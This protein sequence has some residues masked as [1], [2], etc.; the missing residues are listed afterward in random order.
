MMDNSATGLSDQYIYA[1]IFI[2]A[3]TIYLIKMIPIVI[4]RKKIV[5]KKLNK[6]LSYVPYG[7]MTSILFPEAFFST[8]PKGCLDIS[9]YI[10][11]ASIGLLTAII[12]AFI[13]RKMPIIILSTVVIAFI[14]QKILTNIL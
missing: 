10:I 9:A 8:V 7:V 4:F 14:F 13:K 1:C 5:N 2:I 11:S 3:L 12:L 6:F